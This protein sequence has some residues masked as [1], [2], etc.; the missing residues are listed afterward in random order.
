MKTFLKYI[1]FTLLGVV[2]LDLI[3]RPLFVYIYDNPPKGSTIESDLSYIFNKEQSDILILGAS[4]ASRH[5]NCQMFIDSLGKTCFN[6]GHD[7]QPIYNQY[8]DLLKSIENGKVETVFLD[9]SS[10]QLSDKWIKERMLPLVPYYW[11]NDSVRSIID[12]VS[13]RTIPPHVLYCSS[14]I[15]Y[16]SLWH[17]L[18]QLIK[19]RSHNAIHG[20]MPLPYNGEEFH[21]TQRLKDDLAPNDKAIDYLSRIVETCEVNNISLY[22]I[23][24]PSLNDFSPF[25]SFMSEWCAKNNVSL[26]D[27][28]IYPPCFN[29]PYLWKDKSHM[30]CKGA[31]IFTAELIR[32]LRDQ[33]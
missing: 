13:D 4:R 15:Q 1:L 25:I 29:D 26:L 33:H 17:K 16:N 2:V 22:L 8:L 32:F 10:A 11:K 9:I 20:Y 21:Y 7:G 28:S 6:A 24:S 23:V 12:N 19:P 14:L 3:C 27:Y 31:D 30:N 18:P 5:Y